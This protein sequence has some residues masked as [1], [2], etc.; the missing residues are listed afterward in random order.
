MVEILADQPDAVE[1]ITWN[2]ST[3]SHY[4][5]TLWPYS[6]PDDIS[7]DYNHTA[8][9]QLIKPFITAYKSGSTSASDIVPTTGAAV[10]GAMWYR[11]LLKSASCS[12]DSLGKPSGWENAQDAI[13]FGL[14][15]AADTASGQYVINVYTDAA[16]ANTKIGQYDAVAGLNYATAAGVTT[17]QQSLE[18]VDSSTGDVVASATSTMAVEADISSGGVCNFN[19]Q[20]L[21]VVG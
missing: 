1:I 9:Q 2:D 18:V 6:Q 8:W 12:S 3:E 13:N 7:T 11:P 19:Y 17:G 4:I 21:E 16:G 20:V 10:Q 14:V 15:F 5:G